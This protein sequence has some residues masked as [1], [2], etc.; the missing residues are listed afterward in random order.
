[1]AQRAWRCGAARVGP[2]H[3]RRRV[4]RRPVAVGTAS[5]L[6]ASRSKRSCLTAEFL[7]YKLALS[8]VGARQADSECRRRS[9]RRARPRTTR[10]FATWLSTGSAPAQPSGDAAA[11]RAQGELLAQLMRCAQHASTF[12]AERDASAWAGACA[13]CCMRTYDSRSFG[14]LSHMSLVCARLLVG[15]WPRPP[16]GGRP[17]L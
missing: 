13:T 16:R 6:A 15:F 12:R 4:V 2:P 9:C 3:R 17:P 8:A 11:W 10:L 14:A 7:I 5:S 1:M